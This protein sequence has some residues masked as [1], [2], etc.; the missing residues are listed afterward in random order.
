MAGAAKTPGRDYKPISNTMPL[1]KIPVFLQDLDTTTRLRVT[2]GVR[3][4][5]GSELE[6]E[7]GET[8]A[9]YA[10][11]VD[12]ATDDYLNEHNFAVE[13]AI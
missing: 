9:D 3:Y 8:E 10:R 6:P 7:E 11:R 4:A 1:I 12:E 5:L 13:Y 2:E